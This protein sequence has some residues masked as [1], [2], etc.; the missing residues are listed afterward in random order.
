[1]DF[2]LLLSLFNELLT[3]RKLT[4]SYLAEKY[5]VSPRTVYRYVDKLSTLLPLHVRRGRAG[6][7]FLADSYRLPVD[8]L[9]REEYETLLDALSAAYT[10]APEERF[11]SLLHKLSEQS[12]AQNALHGVRANAG[13]VVLL[14]ERGKEG[15][16]ERLRIAQAGIRKRKILRVL[17]GRDRERKEGTVEPH[18][19]VFAKKE[20]FLCA[21]CLIERRFFLLSIE[22][23]SGLSLT[24]LS[25][26]P[27]PY[28]VERLLFDEKEG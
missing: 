26:R 4:A 17:Y 3:A 20:W 19:L 14:P 9:R 13:E 15:F 16:F 27:R 22:G 11:L 23:A 28:D 12:R 8:F 7:I 21:F 6:G 18:A 24:E 10:Q 1:M 5:R 2:T 25:F